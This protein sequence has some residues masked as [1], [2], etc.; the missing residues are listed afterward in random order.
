MKIHYSGLLNH[1]CPLSSNLLSLA[2]DAGASAPSTTKQPRVTVPP[3]V[4]PASHC[5]ASELESATAAGATNTKLS[6]KRRSLKLNQEEDGDQFVSPEL[7]E[8][9][10]PT[11]A[12]NAGD[13]GCTSN[14]GAAAARVVE[15][16][17]QLTLAPHK[18]VLPP[19]PLKDTIAQLV[20]QGKLTHNQA[21]CVCDVIVKYRYCAVV[22]NWSCNTVL[23][24]GGAHWHLYVEN[25]HG[26]QMVLRC[27]CISMIVL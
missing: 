11:T 24:G 17:Q 25:G 2:A 4:C 12:T 27:I 19:P 9:P 18:P 5:S 3:S 23:W 22:L 14:S 26:K 21:S 10:L 8:G 6:S 20:S 16:R 1:Y 13:I 15:D 7:F